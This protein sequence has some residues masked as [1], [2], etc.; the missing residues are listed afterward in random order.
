MLRII[1]CSWS[2]LSF[3]GVEC[4]HQLET[5][6]AGVSKV[7][8]LQSEAP[9]IRLSF[10]PIKKS[11]IDWTDADTIKHIKVVT[12][13]QLTQG[14]DF[15]LYSFSKENALPN[16]YRKSK[17]MTLG[18][19]LLPGKLWIKDI[20]HLTGSSPLYLVGVY[21]YCD[22]IPVLDPT[23]NSTWVHVAN[24]YHKK[25][26]CPEIADLPQATPELMTMLKT[27][28]KDCQIPRIIKSKKL[29]WRRVSSI[30]LLSMQPPLLLIDAS[31]QPLADAAASVD[32]FLA[33]H[34]VM[35]IAWEPFA[36]SESKWWVLVPYPAGMPGH[37]FAMFDTLQWSHPSV[38]QAAIYNAQPLCNVTVQ[39]CVPGCPKTK[40]RGIT[41]SGWGADTGH[42][43]ESSRRFFV[44]FEPMQAAPFKLGYRVTPPLWG[45][46]LGWL[47]TYKG[48][49]SNFLDC[50]FLEHSPCPRIDMD[51]ANFPG[52][53]IVDKGRFEANPANH[54]WS[55]NPPWWDKVMGEATEKLPEFSIKNLH[56]LPVTHSIYTYFFRPKYDLRKIIHDRM[57]KFNLDESSAVMHVRRGDSI[58]HTG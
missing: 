10:P 17:R 9:M 1:L 22:S 40:I 36:E 51:A 20:Y 41:G 31:D 49:E 15:E 12:Y 57:V 4:C 46:T 23:M 34:S 32:A 7:R 35:H 39:G 16:D 48:C 13:P 8:T 54:R 3:F 45:G 21:A 50:Y 26:T 28:L 52:D 6:V 38:M 47:Y 53:A 27:I 37:F 25:S 43:V 55:A 29:D 30:N 11:Q 14:E 5:I 58:M 19:R 44:D 33:A 18:I 24:I 2:L 42:I 56:G